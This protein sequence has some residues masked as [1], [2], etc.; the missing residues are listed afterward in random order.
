M[1]DNVLEDINEKILE[2]VFLI[3]EER[4]YDWPFPVPL[5]SADAGQS[6]RVIEEMLGR[7]PDK[8][9][10]FNKKLEAKITGRGIAWDILRITPMD[11]CVAALESVSAYQVSAHAINGLP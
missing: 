9:L 2:C 7:H 10:E 4:I 6:R 1:N 3:P 8:C 11:I 5:F